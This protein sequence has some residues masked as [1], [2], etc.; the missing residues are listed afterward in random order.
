MFCA[1]IIRYPR[2]NSWYT[3]ATINNLFFYLGVNVTLDVFD[4][5]SRMN[6]WR[7]G[8]VKIT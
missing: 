1:I 4:N 8:N 6:V 7:L 5:L 2:P 3:S